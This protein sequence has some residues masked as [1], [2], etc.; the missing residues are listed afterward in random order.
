MKPTALAPGPHPGFG[1][2]KSQSGIYRCKLR[3]EVNK[4]RPEFADYRGTLQLA[5]GAKATVPPLGA[6]GR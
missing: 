2:L 5:G 6:P 4:A 1:K 3:P